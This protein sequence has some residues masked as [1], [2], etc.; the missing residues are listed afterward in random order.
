MNTYSTAWRGAALIMGVGLAAL[1]ARG[2]W[3]YAKA[4]EGTISYVVIAAPVVGIAAGILPSI[5][6]WQWRENAKVKSALLWFA[7]A[8]CAVTVG[9]AIVERM[10]TAKAT[11]EAERAALRAAVVRAKADYDAKLV[12][13][14][15][16]ALA[17]DRTAGWKTC[18]PQCQG[19]RATSDRLNTELATARM[20]LAT[21]EQA[22]VTEAPLKLPSWWLAAAMSVTEVLLIWAGL[23]GPRPGEEKPKAKRRRRKA[24]RKPKAPI[25]PQ[26]NVV[27][28]KVA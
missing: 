19:I 6:E 23:T 10:H 25:T 16:A 4:L 7:F 22:A 3:E 11:G 27:P 28:I 15:P 18:G 17:K 1:G 5:A 12:E 14:A 13:V 21:A 2:A 8:L 26:G 9:G 24:A 20:A